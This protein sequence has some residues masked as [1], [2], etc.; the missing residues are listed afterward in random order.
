MNRQTASLKELAKTMPQSSK[1]ARQYALVEKALEGL[2]EA[3]YTLTP[4]KVTAIEIQSLE[5]V[6]NM[7]RAACDSTEDILS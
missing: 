5:S 4:P 3:I 6:R 7:L 2:E 1:A